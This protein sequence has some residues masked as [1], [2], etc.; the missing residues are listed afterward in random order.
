MT[1]H[2]ST[3]EGRFL[4]GDRAA[5]A[6]VVRWI[7]RVVASSSFWSLRSEWTDL[8]QEAM[9][10]VLE[11]LRQGR[12][13]PS[14]EFRA[15]VQGVA[16]FTA[17]KAL[18]R[19]ARGPVLPKEGEDLPEPPVETEVETEVV[20]QQLARQ[21]LEHAS[22]ECRGLMQA[23]FIEERGYAEIAEQ[24]GWPVGTVKSKLFRC[25]E[26]A[27]RAFGRSSGGSRRA[28]RP[29]GIRSASS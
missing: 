11:S 15:Y 4:S 14:Q 5:V 8:H 26:A 18:G 19:Q 27:H 22:E 9:G 23:Y 24:L 16:R 21:V 1:Y 6:E 20:T 2:E 12:F 7:A 25:L 13:D 29:K 17:L 3:V 28:P 10:R